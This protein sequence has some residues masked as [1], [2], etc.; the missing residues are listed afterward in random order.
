MKYKE[1]KGKS[2]KEC[3]EMLNSIN[4]KIMDT[5]NEKNEE[6]SPV[7]MRKS[8]KKDIARILTYKN[9][10]GEATQND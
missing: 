3:D 1:L 6:Q 5:Y 7:K 10:N 2:S 4:Q 8:L 9:Q